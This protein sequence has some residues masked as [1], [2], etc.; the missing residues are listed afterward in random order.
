MGVAKIELKKR[1][2]LLSLI[3]I[4]TLDYYDMLTMYFYLF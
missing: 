1:N 2:N 4:T 3:L